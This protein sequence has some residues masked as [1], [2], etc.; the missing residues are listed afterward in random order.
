MFIRAVRY[1][2]GDLSH[3]EIRKFSV[4]GGIFFLLIGSYW[5]L[6]TQKD[7]VFDALVGLSYQPRAKIL[8]W[9]VSII[10]VL[11]YSKLVDLLGNKKLLL[12]LATI[13]GA[14]FMAI[15]YCLEFSS[16]GFANPIASPDRIFGWVIYVLIESLGSLMVGL[17]WAFVT[18]TTDATSAKKGYPLVI[19][20]SQCGSLLGSY[21]SWQSEWFGNPFL[22][23]AGAVSL[24]LIV[25]MVFWYVR[26]IASHEKPTIAVKV[27]K[28]K[29]GIWEGLILL[30]TRPYVGAIL[31]VSTI[32]E[33]ITTILE[34]EMKLVAKEIY[35]TREAFASFNGMYGMFVNGLALLFATNT[36]PPKPQYRPI[37]S[38]IGN[39]IRSSNGECTCDL[40]VSYNIPAST[41]SLAK[42]FSFNAVERK[43]LILRGPE[44]IKPIIKRSIMCSEIPREITYS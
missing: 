12:V 5:L 24:G 31:I 40:P 13:F 18:S 7:A 3:A 4:L 44:G 37:L 8:S 34:Y 32:Y 25:P 21:C 23:G 10:L 9:F 29:T 14:S 11:V 35:V 43:A 30:L 16:F 42:I 26:I 22:F 20:G 2:W 33:V 28:P 17:F 39:T 6:R 19:V 1:L 38:V 27:H 41:K 36:R 15:A